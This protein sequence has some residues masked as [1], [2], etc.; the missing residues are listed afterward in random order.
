LGPHG[1]ARL[2][3]EVGADAFGDV[4]QQVA[5]VDDAA[6]GQELLDPFADDWGIL[7]VLQ[8]QEAREIEP[9][10][11]AVL[12]GVGARLRVHLQLQVM[13]AEMLD[14]E[15]GREAQ[16]LRRDQRLDDCHGVRKDVVDPLLTGDRLDLQAR[17]QDTDV[18]GGARPE[19]HAVLGKLHQLRI[20]VGGCVLDFDKGG[21]GSAPLLEKRF[22]LIVSIP[23]GKGGAEVTDGAMMRKMAVEQ[24]IPLFTDV[25][26]VRFLMQALD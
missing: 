8:R 11:R 13:H 6:G 22:D 23:S 5:A 21:H 26:V 4:A 16:L 9:I 17:A 1:L 19:H 14:G 15:A 2:I 7:G 10:V 24:Q 3:G 12:K 20:A 25:Q 18:M